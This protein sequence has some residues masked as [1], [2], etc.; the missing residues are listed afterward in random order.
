[1]NTFGCFVGRRHIVWSVPLSLANGISSGH[2]RFRVL[3]I[4]SIILETH[5]LYASIY[6]YKIFEEKSFPFQ[7]YESMT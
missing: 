7:I 4:M 6:S 5:F 1:M 2:R 3:A